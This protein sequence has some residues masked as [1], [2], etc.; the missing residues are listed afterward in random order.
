[1]IS[2]HD[3][4]LGRLFLQCPWRASAS[5]EQCAWRLA[6]LMA[7]HYAGFR[8]SLGALRSVRPTGKAALENLM[9]NFSS[10]SGTHHLCVR[11]T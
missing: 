8:R 2:M 7:E 3:G 9:K 4:L 10:R 5:V 11:V 1:V 6:L